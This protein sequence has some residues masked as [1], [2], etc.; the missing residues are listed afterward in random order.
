MLFPVMF[1]AVQRWDFFV[2]LRQMFLK[3]LASVFSVPLG[4]RSATSRLSLNGTVIAN[5]SV[6]QMDLSRRCLGC[7]GSLNTGYT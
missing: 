6:L 4:F 7:T 3:A 5:S 2:F 1:V